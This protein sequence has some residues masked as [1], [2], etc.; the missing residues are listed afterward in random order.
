M[1]FQYFDFFYYFF[2]KG[3]LVVELFLLDAFE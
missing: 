2:A 1:I 3:E